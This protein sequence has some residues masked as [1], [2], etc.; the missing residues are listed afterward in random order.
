MLLLLL[1]LALILPLFAAMALAAQALLDLLKRD[2]TPFL[3]P[4]HVSSP[5]GEDH[6]M[7]A[8]VWQVHCLAATYCASSSGSE[9]CAWL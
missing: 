2:A 8:G 3:A 4:V 9:G 7:S 6:S 1:T 5:S